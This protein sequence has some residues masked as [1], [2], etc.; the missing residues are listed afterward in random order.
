MVKKYAQNKCLLELGRQI[1]LHWPNILWMLVI[2]TLNHL[3]LKFPTIALPVRHSRRG[4]FYVITSELE[5]DKA[6]S[7]F[8]FYH[9][10]RFVF[11][12]PFLGLLF[13]RKYLS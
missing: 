10:R 7:L 5:K 12:K 2:F 1:R 11:V 6:W 9:F 3:L 4:M 13:T 8:K